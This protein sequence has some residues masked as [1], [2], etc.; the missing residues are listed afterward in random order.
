MKITYE[1]WQ[2]DN[3]VTFADQEGI[4]QFK[5]KGLFFGKAKLLHTIVADTPEE[6]MA[7]HHIKMGWE[8]YKPPED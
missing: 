7:A 2:D 5:D 6:A 4:K 3:G 1:A 8:P